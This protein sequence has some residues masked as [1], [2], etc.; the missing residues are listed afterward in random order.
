[1]LTQRAHASERSTYHTTMNPSCGCNRC[2]RG[3]G[4]WHVA[5][6]QG[7][8]SRLPLHHETSLALTRTT[9]RDR[10]QPRNNRGVRQNKEGMPT[11][12]TVKSA[13]T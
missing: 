7:H 1:M 10:K 11:Y 9:E 6:F 13:K 5:L 3:G 4:P 12:F 2:F 8:P